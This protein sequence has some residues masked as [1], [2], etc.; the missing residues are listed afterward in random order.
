MIAS[1][2]LQGYGEA[3]SADIGTTV[4]QGNAVVQTVP[5]PSDK[6]IQA[7]VLGQVGT[8]MSGDIAKYSGRPPPYIIPA[9]RVMNVLITQELIVP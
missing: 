4:T 2:A 6:Q 1:S 3:Y 7:K 5:E 8:T 9:G